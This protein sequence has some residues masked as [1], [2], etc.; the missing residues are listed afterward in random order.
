MSYSIKIE[1]VSRLEGKAQILF[2][3]DE[4][5][6]NV[7]KAEFKV[8]EFRAFEKFMEKRMARELPRITPR[9]CGICPVS[10]H[11]ASVKA[12]DVLARTI[13]PER[14]KLH[15]ELMHM[16]QMIH[17]HILHV[18]FL[19]MPDYI[20]G[21]KAESNDFR[22]IL[23]KYPEILKKVIR[24]RK[25]GQNIIEVIGGKAIHP[26]TAIP[27]GISQPITENDRLNLLREGNELISVTK[28]V[29]D[30]AWQ[31]ID[32]VPEDLK[33]YEH[34]S[35]HQLGLVSPNKEITLYD[36]DSV[37]IGPDGTEKERFRGAGY[38][39]YIEERHYPFSWTKF[40]YYRHETEEE[41][42]ILQVGPLARQ[43]IYDTIPTEYASDMLN[44]FRNQF[45]RYTT[46]NFANNH[47]RVMEIMYCL[48]NAIKI[49]DD[50]KTMSDQPYRIKSPISEAIGVGIIE[51]PRGTVI[52]AYHSNQEGKIEK[53]NIIVAT[54]FNNPAINLTLLKVA[55]AKLNGVKKPTGETL[56][57]IESS[58]RV[59][60]PCLTCSSHSFNNFQ[61]II[62]NKEGKILH[63]T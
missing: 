60:D 2:E 52:H 34:L 17:S 40:P 28:E 16:G 1:P 44:K 53:T 46:D 18:Y 56:R 7:D 8:L 32:A 58:V 12:T 20:D 33:K 14:A 4:K 50:L 51:A 26:V 36:G 63:T 5:T 38:S 31:L 3:I 13:I 41:R 57:Y 27:G 24:I 59:F 30:T 43:K 45:G 42:S 6:H 55:R 62:K 29:L 47:A 11:L 23:K 19:A 21:F 54:T 22:L 49:L 48:E 15:R 10:H 25:Y 39:D 61:I 35:T 37:I 9:I